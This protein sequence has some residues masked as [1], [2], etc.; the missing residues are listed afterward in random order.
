M[1]EGQINLVDYETLMHTLP[2]AISKALYQED[3]AEIS[4]PPKICINTLQHMGLLE[5]EKP[6]PEDE[7]EESSGLF[8]QVTD[9][10]IL[11]KGLRDERGQPANLATIYRYMDARGVL[12]SYFVKPAVK[13]IA[14]FFEGR[15]DYGIDKFIDDVEARLDEAEVGYLAQLTKEIA[16]K[17]TLRRA[18]RNDDLNYAMGEL[19]YRKS[20]FELKKMLNP[21]AKK[22]RNARQPKVNLSYK[23]YC[24]D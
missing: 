23:E 18:Q 7:I 4:G 15:K 11:E 19:N 1:A 17:D 2:G 16:E 6:G 8:T 3:L 10:G 21:P 12:G 9:S 13:T 24:C 5:G 20:L 14:G 22:T